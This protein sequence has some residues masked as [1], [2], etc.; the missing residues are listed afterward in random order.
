MIQVIEIPMGSDPA[1]FFANLFLSQKE[2]DWVK[3]QSKLGTINV[4]KINNSYWSIDDML[5]L[6]DD[7]TFEKQYK[8]IYPTELELKKENNSNSCTPFLDIYIYT[9]IGEFNTKLFDKWHNFGFNMKGC[10]FTAPMSLVKCSMGALE[11]SF[12]EFLEQPVKLK[13]FLI[14]VNSC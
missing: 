13:I 7:N 9:E 10:H 3:A 12:L 8:D 4:W 14:L 2:A 11:Q 6:K 5:S 1:P